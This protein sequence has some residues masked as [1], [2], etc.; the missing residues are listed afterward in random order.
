ML[1]VV[2]LALPLKPML[3]PFPTPL[4]L[5]PLLALVLLVII[6]MLIRIN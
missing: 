2:V 3:S 1:L 5:L 6:R 4:L